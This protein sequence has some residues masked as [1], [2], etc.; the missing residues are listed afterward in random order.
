[1]IY[2]I[3]SELSDAAQKKIESAVENAVEKKVHKEMMGITKKLTLNFLIS[4]AALACA[5]IVANNADK[6]VNVIFSKNKRKK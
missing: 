5:I 1:M 2:S 4:G 6:I 3:K